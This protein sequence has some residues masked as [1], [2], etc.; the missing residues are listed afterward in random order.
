[1][2][3]YHLSIRTLVE[4]FFLIMV[5][6]VVSGF[7]AMFIHPDFWYLSTLAF[8]VFLSCLLGMDFGK[9]HPDYTLRDSKQQESKPAGYHRLAH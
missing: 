9:S 2:R 6:I 1:M 4:R 8:A 7:G 5:I 3:L